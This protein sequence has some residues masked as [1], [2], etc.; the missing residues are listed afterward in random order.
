MRPSSFRKAMIEPVNVTAP[1]ASPI[2]ISM[3][4]PGWMTPTSSMP[5]ASGAYSAP[6]ATRTAARPT[7]EWNIATSCGIAV[8]CT[9]RARHAPMPPPMA[10]PKMMSSQEIALEG[11][12]SAS[13]VTTAIAMPSMPKRLPWRDVA[14][15]ESPRSARMK[16]MPETR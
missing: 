10:M 9:V 12:R 6:A 15:E 3:M 16:R 5:K 7:S 11:G 2:D 8:I 1:I 14:G 4:L 13:V